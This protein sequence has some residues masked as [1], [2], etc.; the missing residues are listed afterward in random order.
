MIDTSSTVTSPFGVQKVGKGKSPVLPEE[1]DPSFNVRD[2]L[3]DVLLSEKHIIE[4]Y[5]TGSKEVLC[6]QLYNVVTENLSNLK[7]AQRHLFEELFNLGEYQAD[8]AA[9]PQID[10]AL[11]MF[12]KYKVQLPYP[13]S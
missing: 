12:T 1:K 9:Q 2:R 11:D 5:T 10:D 7:L 6:Q 13:Q 4:S 8:I 3:N